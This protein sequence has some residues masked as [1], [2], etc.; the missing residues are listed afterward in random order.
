MENEKLLEKCPKFNKCDA[1]ICP[2]DFEMPKKIYWGGDNLCRQT[3]NR[4]NKIANKYRNQ[5]LWIFDGVF[6]K[7]KFYAGRRRKK[8]QTRGFVRSSEAR[9]KLKQWSEYYLPLKK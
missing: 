8:S 3:K 7:T 9:K 5:L 2:L 1:P 4:I 6:F